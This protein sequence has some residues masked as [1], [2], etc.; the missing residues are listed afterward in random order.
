MRSI[1][2]FPAAVLAAFCLASALPARSDD[3]WTLDRVLAEAARGQP[4]SAALRA[5]ARGARDDAVVAGALPPPMWRAGIVN[6]PVTGSD[7]FDPNVDDMTMRMVGIE[8]A[9]PSRAL[10]EA[11][12]GMQGARAG[13]LDAEAAMRARMRQ[14][15]A[16]MAWL[17]A[18][19]AQR[20][21]EL[22][23][24]Q[25]DLLAQAESAALAAAA[26]MDGAAGEALAWQAMRAM[27][28]L[29]QV[30]DRER[31]AQALEEL[32]GAVGVALESAQLAPTL[33]DW[34]APDPAAL[35]A[36]LDR[37]PDVARLEAEAREADAERAMR[38]AEARPQWTW[39]LGYGERMPGM[40]EMASLEVRV[41]FDGLFGR[42]QSAREGAAA[43]RVEAAGLRRDD[44]LRRLAADLER[45]LVAHEH[46]FAALAVV[47]G[48]LL[49]LR[50]RQ[51]E[52]AQAR[53]A[54]G[55][56][57]LMPVFEARLALLEVEAERWM[58]LES[59]WRARLRL[60]RL[61][62]DRNVEAAP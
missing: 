19:I 44:R 2:R 15:R 57:A 20:R 12:A 47:D 5:A 10:R 56:G 37:L 42:R 7:A 58:S 61:D 62:A 53:Y 30:R 38:A 51:F 25:L 16:G 34:P 29:E 21:L 11:G 13:M 43:A 33:P 54:Q 52:V 48:R 40:P 45:A 28:E 36:G 14:E 23:Q 1:L 18:W 32:E 27:R 17:D 39:M 49:P 3:P 46:A 35:R 31:L 9:W 22:Q 55:G 8:Q 50:R 4:D 26:E 41:S 24:A 60:L 6:L 59:L